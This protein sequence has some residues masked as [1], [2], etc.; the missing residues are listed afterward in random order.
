[1]TLGARSF[2]KHRVYLCFHLN[3][4]LTFPNCFLFRPYVCC[5]AFPSSEHRAMARGIEG[6]EISTQKKK[7]GVSSTPSTGPKQL[8]I[9]GFFQRKPAAAPSSVTPAKRPSDEA[10]ETS[11]KAASSSP[12]LTPAP[13][14]GA[15][16]SSSPFTAPRAS[17]HSSVKDNLDKENGMINHIVVGD[18]GN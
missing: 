16:A 1:M 13:S 18:Q 17:Q 9:A 14:N 8:G 5:I 12:G 3:W 4:T 15:P 6:N 7:T 2:L 11:S 10:I